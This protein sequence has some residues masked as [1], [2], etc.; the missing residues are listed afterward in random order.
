M[1]LILNVKKNWC[2]NLIKNVKALINVC[3][4]KSLHSFR[5]FSYNVRLF[6]FIKS[7][8]FNP[9]YVYVI[10]THIVLTDTHRN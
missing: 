6:P 10:I 9:S 7:N 8:S 3:S 1:V 2:S 5:K 4:R